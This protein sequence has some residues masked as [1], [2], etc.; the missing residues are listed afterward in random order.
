MR[1]EVEIEDTAGLP[2]ETAAALGLTGLLLAVARAM[3]AAGLT[4]E[5][6]IARIGPALDAAW[7]AAPS[8]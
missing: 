5:Q 8:A 2:P 3:R 4:R 1:V 6:A 7:D